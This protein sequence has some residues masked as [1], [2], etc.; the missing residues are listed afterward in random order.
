VRVA[1]GG[2]ARAAPKAQELLLC[3]LIISAFSALEAVAEAAPA[4][5]VVDVDSDA[6][7]FF[8]DDGTG[9]SGHGVE[10]VEDWLIR[11]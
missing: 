11:G 10:Y 1:P 9:F 4:L 6:D 8:V 2:P 5:L 3:D 7:D